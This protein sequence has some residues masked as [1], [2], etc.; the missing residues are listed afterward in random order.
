MID[1]SPLPLDRHSQQTLSRSLESLHTGG[2]LPTDVRPVVRDSWMRA[3]RAHVR[4]DLP[5]APIVMSEDDLHAARLRNDW[6]QLAVRAVERQ[7]D[8]YAAGGHILTL[9]DRDGRMLHHEGDPAALEQLQSINFRPGALW[10]EHAVGTNGPGTALATGK[11]VHIVGSEHFC[12]GWQRWHCAAVPIRDQ[13]TGDI[14]GAVDISGHRDAAHPHTLMLTVAIAI[15]VEQM[16]AARDM[17]RR[18]RVLRYFAELSARWPGDALVAVDRTGTVLGASAAA[19]AELHP[20][21]PVPERL[22][23]VLVE[24]VEGFSGDGPKEV[25]VPCLGDRRVV[26]HPVFEQSRPIGACLVVDAP[27]RR[28]HG[29]AR[30]A[31][32][33]GRERGRRGG[34]GTR[35]SLDD[36]IGESATLREAHRVAIAAAANTLPVL[37]L[38]ESG[39]GKEM[40][41]QGIHAASARAAQPFIAVNCGALP[42]ELVESELFGYVGGAFS[43]ARREGGIGKFEAANGGTIFLDEIGELPLSAQAAL[44]RVLEEGEV[45]R[46]G[47][48]RGIPI[49][50]RVIAATNR[51]VDAEMRGG[52]FREDL[53]Y[54]IGVLSMRLPALRERRGDIGRLAQRFLSEAEADLGRSGYSFAPE[55]LDALRAYAW[56]GN[57]RELK[58]LIWRTVALATTGRITPADLPVSV[59]AAWGA[60]PAQIAPGETVSAGPLPYTSPPSTEVDAQAERERLVN[61]VERAANMAEAAELLGVARS[62]LYRQLAKYGLQARRVV[63]G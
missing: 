50:V 52:G 12:E 33:D 11:P 45:T 6:L 24:L 25:W 18:A 46:V 63:R 35:Y 9:F 38:G 17:E 61:A 36:L 59:R 3:V 55:A 39:T 42:G 21:A 34:G 37:L 15:A 60:P 30:L 2:A 16:L 56:P 28:A 32:A 47:A 54:R 57:I 23:M 31:P 8:A 27:A 14:H 29:A 20:L 19:P 22:R 43:G 13:L 7:R 51:D 58:N 62:T 26:A 5:H 53:Y 4:G 1:P 40:F 41:A 44:L 48:A 49:D 10:A